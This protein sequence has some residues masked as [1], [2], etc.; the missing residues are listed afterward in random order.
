MKISKKILS[1]ILAALMALSVL[2][3]AVS[4]NGNPTTALYK[5]KWTFTADTG[6]GAFKLSSTGTPTSLSFTADQTGKTSADTI[7]V[8]PG[9]M[10]KIHVNVSTNYYAGTFQTN[11]FY[12]S[13]LLDIND[14]YK[15][16]QNK[17]TN[18]SSALF[19]KAYVWNTTSDYGA[20]LYS[21]I[22]NCWSM[23]DTNNQENVGWPKTDDGKEVLTHSDWKY[24]R[25][26]NFPDTDKTTE[27]YILSDAVELISFPLFVPSD[28]AAGT[29]YHITLPEGTIKRVAQ[30]TCYFYLNQYPNGVVDATCASLQTYSEDYYYDLAGTNLT[31]KVAGTT[32]LDYSALQTKYD[33]VKNTV[34]TN[35]TDASVSAFTTALANSKTML[36]SKNAA[37]QTAIDTQL[38]ALTTAFTGLTE[39][40]ADYTALNTAKTSAAA[41][42]EANYTAASWAN[43][44]TALTAANAVPTGLKISSQATIDTATTNLNNAI[45]ALEGLAS[46][47]ALDAAI[48]SA[49]TKTQSWYTTDSW[50][51]LAT[52][53]TAGKALSRTLGTTQQATVDAAT[54]AIT[55]A[56]AGLVEADASYTALNAAIAQAD[57]L[58]E[59]DYS[60]ASWANLQTALTAAKAVDKTLKVKDQAT[61][62]TA[63]KNLTDAIAALAGLASYT[64]LDAAIAQADALT[65]ANYTTDSWATLA[66]AVSAG[67]ALSRTLTSADQAT[68]DAA[69]K[70]ITDAIAGLVEASASYTALNA[71]IA[72]ADALTQ[73]NYTTASWATLAN[74]LTA[75]KAVDKTLKVKDQATIDTATKNLTDAIAALKYNS[76]DKTAL[77]AAIAK[78]ETIDSTLYT[79]DSYANMSSALASAKTLND[80]T[81]LNITNQTDIDNATAALNEAYNALVP[82]GADYKELNAQ[83]AAYEALTEAN[84]TATTWAA[85]KTAYDAAKAVPTTLTKADQATIDT[86]ATNL[87]NAIAALVEADADYTAVDAAIKT[88]PAASNEFRYTDD[89][90]AAVKTAVAAVVRGLKHKDQATVDGYAAAINAA[91]KA[92]VYKPFDY[93]TT[94]GYVTTWNGLKEDNYT[95]ATWAAAKTLFDNINWNYT[96]AVTDYAAGMLQASHLKTALANLVEA[97]AADYTAV[98]TAIATAN[99]LD[100]T[101]YTADSYKAVTDAVAAV[102]T[103]LNSNHQSEVDAMAKAIN[104]AIAA[105]VPVANADYTALDAAIAQANGLTAAS[106]TAAS[107]ATMQTALTEAK[108]VSRTLKEADQ[109]TV[110]AAKTKLVNAITALETLASYTALDKAIADAAALNQNDYTTESWATLASAVTAGKAVSRTLGTTQQTTVD[111]ATK[112]ITDAIAALVKKAVKSSITSTAY[113]PSESTTNNFNVTINGRASKVQFVGPDG[114]TMT[115]DRYNSN[116]TI[117]SYK[118]DGTECSSLSKDL[119]YEVWTINAKI[120]N[121]T[122][123]KA[124]AKMGSTWETESY[125][126]D[127]KTAAPVKDYTLYSATLASTSGTDNK[128]TATVTTGIDV[129]KI[130]FTYS[131]G[132]TATLDAATYAKTVDGKLVYTFDAYTGITGTN[133]IAI[134]LKEGSTWVNATETLSYSHA[135]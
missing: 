123:I 21:G 84:Y 53:V 127:V 6:V 12:S 81:T 131:D 17:T 5:S 29:E 103:G 51:A 19:N 52:A 45:A 105:L 16:T 90:I 37:D 110:D 104:D 65:Q 33:A 50:S 27:T 2:A 120:D 133:T 24:T 100:S 4:A 78:A 134:A 82:L 97:G 85:A 106:Y 80:D 8:N 102:V 49:A 77:A 48:A 68:V 95:P 9:D 18:M 88:A 109:A 89:T 61:I 35:Y 75:A 10:I 31:F 125:A 108:A 11:V 118:A 129:A 1:V 130:R 41:L 55:D 126:F 14:F 121:G 87:K 66:T 107:W 117:K 47:T 83:I 57:A 93:T 39:K 3:V 25:F 112:A 62:D 64:A 20:I 43:L 119:A 113:T 73:A 124:V 98:N 58:K 36:D 132:G 63:T 96:M 26:G 22:S 69:T 60:A 38:A 23:M 15:K 13:G 135:K 59:A 74:A 116:V 115:F 111:S 28:A 99:A 76:A 79:T 44:Q 7:M 91:V 101:G 34:T 92:L 114:G 54:K 94:N 122:S 128:V 42:T 40:D 67:K 86:A 46:Y 70:A 30:P 56:I 32:A 72:Q 71:A